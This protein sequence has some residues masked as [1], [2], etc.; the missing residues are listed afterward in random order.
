[1]SIEKTATEL[2]RDYLREWR[3]RHPEKVRQYN[4]EYWKRR[5]EREKGRESNNAETA[6][7]AE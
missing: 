4:I 2:R 3:R 5:A 1:M 6:N 7:G